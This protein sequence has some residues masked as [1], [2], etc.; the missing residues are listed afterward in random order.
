MTILLEAS[1]EYSYCECLWGCISSHLNY[2]MLPNRV[3]ATLCRTGVH[4]VW[5]PQ[6]SAGWKCFNIQQMT[7]EGPQINRLDVLNALCICEILARRFSN[8]HF[9]VMHLFMVFSSK[10]TFLCRGAI[11]TNY[12]WIEGIVHEGASLNLFLILL[13]PGWKLTVE[14]SPFYPGSLVN[15]KKIS[16]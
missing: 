11:T 16:G 2:Q 5:L 9:N 6:S 10:P 8:L 1:A 3:S 14:V 13:C 7:A 4:T 12:L 15:K